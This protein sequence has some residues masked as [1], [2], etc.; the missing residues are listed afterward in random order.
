MFRLLTPWYIF[1]SVLFV[2]FVGFG[3]HQY[4]KQ[5]T[6]TCVVIAGGA[7]VAILSLVFCVHCLS[8]LF[9]GR[10][11]QTVQVC[12]DGVQVDADAFLSFKV[13][14]EIQFSRS[15]LGVMRMVTSLNDGTRHVFAVPGH[16]D[17]PQLEQYLRKR[18]KLAPDQ[19]K[20][21]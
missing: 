5:L 3:F 12:H 7:Y 15:K 19:I 16:I 13:I 17:I 10:S 2:C 21:R 14:S 4:P 8:L 11:R 9:A 1:V 18:V 6:W 20:R